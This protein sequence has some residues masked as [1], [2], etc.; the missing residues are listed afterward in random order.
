MPPR[1]A[2]RRRQVRR[3]CRSEYKWGVPNEDGV[4]CDPGQTC[5]LKQNNGS[6]TEV[7]FTTFCSSVFRDFGFSAWRAY[8]SNSLDGS[9]S[10]YCRS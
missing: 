5:T 10:F 4:V 9:H 2:R 3:P 6:Y 8:E 1:L 7:P